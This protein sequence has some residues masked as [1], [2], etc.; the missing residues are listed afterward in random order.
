MC[1]LFSI[2]WKTDPNLSLTSFGKGFYRPQVL[3]VVSLTFRLTE[4]FEVVCLPENC[5]RIRFLQFFIC[6]LLGDWSVPHKF[7][8]LCIE[9][10]Y[11]NIS[12]PNE[13]AQ[14][15]QLY[16]NRNICHWVLLL[17][18]KVTT[19]EFQHL[20]INTSSSEKIVQLAK[21]KATTHLLTYTP[22]FSGRH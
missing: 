22:T 10:P 18:R 21:T 7:I 15:W 6:E 3:F 4:Q 14:I 13:G 9:T 16:S 20:E 8:E 2:L 12:V 5:P 17:K 11:Y 19:L 1:S